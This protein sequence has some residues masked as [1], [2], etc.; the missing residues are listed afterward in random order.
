MV[1][2]SIEVTATDE[3]DADP[4]CRIA[5]VTCNEPDVGEPDWIITGDLDLEL[6]AERLGCSTGRVYT[7]TVECSDESGNLSSSQVTVTVP[8]D[9][10]KK[11]NVNPRP[12]RERGPLFHTRP[13]P[14]CAKHTTRCPNGPRF[15]RVSKRL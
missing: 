14:M 4:A 9:C 7:I 15:H 1:P 5:S 13:A 2:V 10:K 6:R 8:H 3:E 11:C 12:A